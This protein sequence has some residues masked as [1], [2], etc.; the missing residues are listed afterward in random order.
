MAT[1]ITAKGDLIV[2]TGSGTFDNLPAGTNGHT[3]VA[4]S[5]EAT[6]L[7]WVAPA[8]AAFIGCALKATNDQST[9]LNTDVA[10]TFDSEDFDTDAFHD[11]STNTSRITIPSG[12]G[13]KYLF[14]FT[15]T[16]TN[17]T[18]NANVS[19]PSLFKNG[20]L[21]VKTEGLFSNLQYRYM[22]GSHL[23]DLAAADYIELKYFGES[24]G[25]IKSYRTFNCI[26]VG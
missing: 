1:E 17:Q 18:P 20:S 23:L 16:D 2:G 5:V 12:L 25:T 13:G 26:K 3:L 22:A 7:K 10:I 21:I 6:G 15:I 24:T 8:G 14:T 19:R 9:T 11:N 4:D